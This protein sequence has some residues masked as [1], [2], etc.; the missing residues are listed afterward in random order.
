MHTIFQDLRYALRQLRQSPGFTAAALLTLAI[1]IGANTASFS[2][3]DAV[4][5]HP[6]TVPDVDHVL[7][8]Q[9]QQDRS[10]LRPVAL[11]N[12]EDWNRLNRSFEAL[13]I[14]RSADMALEGSGDAM[15][16]Q[17]EYASPSFFSVMRANP[18]LGRVFD[19]SETNPV[20]TV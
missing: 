4:I 17:A 15:H 18:L 19:Q 6:L 8:V 12:Y 20:G 2:I 3:M 11:A 10:D 7:T 5:L 14:H 9:E 13:A 16:V 1:G